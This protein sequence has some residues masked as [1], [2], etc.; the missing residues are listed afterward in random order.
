MCV[1]AWASGLWSGI[2][3]RSVTVKTKCAIGE[4]ICSNQ[5]DCSVGGICVGD[6]ETNVE[7]APEIVDE[8]P[9]I[10]LKTYNFLSAFASIKR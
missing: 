6:L 5:I 2:V 9:S 3:N 4:V 1:C 7:V 8:P 10:Q